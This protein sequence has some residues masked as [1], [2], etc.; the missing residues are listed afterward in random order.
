MTIVIGFGAGVD[1]EQLNAIAAAGG[2]RYDTY[3]DAQGADELNAALDDIAGSMVACVYDIA[4]MESNVE[5]DTVN[6]YF[7]GEAVPRD[8]GCR[9][10]TG[11]TYDNDEMTRVRFC[12]EPCKDLNDGDPEDITAEAGC[13]QIVVV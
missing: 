4:A 5:P 9:D 7:D 10:G 11:W 2:S 13:V 6:F 1:P 12:E 8:D 3:L